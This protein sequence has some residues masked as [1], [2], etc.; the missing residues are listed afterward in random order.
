MQINNRG[1]DSDK[2]NVISLTYKHVTFI[3]EIN[4]VNLHKYNIILY[5][6]RRIS[7]I[8]DRIYNL[9]LFNPYAGL[10]YIVIAYTRK[11]S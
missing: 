3:Y 6:Q 10:S 1:Y 11:T 2:K 9:Y 5:Q 4:S 8:R 7:P